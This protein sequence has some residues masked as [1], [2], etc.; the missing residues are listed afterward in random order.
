MRRLTKTLLIACISL[1]ASLSF[2]DYSEHP[3]AAA[4]VETMVSKHSF[5]RA[6]IIGWLSYSLLGFRS[7]SAG[8]RDTAPRSHGACEPQPWPGRPDWPGRPGDFQDF[9]RA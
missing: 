4:F 2:A 1:Y 5:E 9:P 3:E 7:A 6:E 8:V